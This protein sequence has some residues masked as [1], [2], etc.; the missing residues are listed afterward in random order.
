MPEV[1]AVNLTFLYFV[2]DYSGVKC[3]NTQLKII[4]IHNSRKSEIILC[5]VR[6][7]WSELIFSNHIH[8]QIPTRHIIK[9]YTISLI[10]EVFDKNEYPLK[11]AAVYNEPVPV[12]Q[13]EVITTNRFLS[14]IYNRTHAYQQF[15]YECPLWHY[16]WL[17]HVEHGSTIDF[18]SIYMNCIGKSALVVY[19]GPKSIFLL[20]ELQNCSIAKHVNVTQSQYFIS[21]VKYHPYSY[22]NNSLTLVVS[23]QNSIKHNVSLSKSG[24]SMWTL[25]I[26]HTAGL[27]NHLVI[28]QSLDTK[29]Y[30]MIEF[31]VTIFDG[32]AY[33]TCTYGGLVLTTFDYVGKFKQ[34]QTFADFVERKRYGPYCDRSVET[35]LIGSSKGIVLPGLKGYIVLYAFHTD[36]I[37]DLTMVLSLHPCEGLINPQHTVY[38]P[39]LLYLNDMSTV[40]RS[41]PGSVTV[42]LRELQ[43]DSCIV[44][45]IFPLIHGTPSDADLVIRAFKMELSFTINFYPRKNSMINLHA[46]KCSYLVNLKYITEADWATKY[47]TITTERTRIALHSGCSQLMIT[48]Q[49][50][51]CQMYEYGTFIMKVSLHE[52]NDCISFNSDNNVANERLFHVLSPCGFLILHTYL[53]EPTF[54]FMAG[55]IDDRLLF[56]SKVL[57]N[58][59]YW[60]MVITNSGSCLGVDDNQTKFSKKLRNM[61]NIYFVDNLNLMDKRKHALMFIIDHKAY[62]G[63]MVL[64]FPKILSP[65]CRITVRYRLDKQKYNYSLSESICGKGNIKVSYSPLSYIQPSWY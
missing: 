5:G 1:F 29:Q 4:T 28:F 63:V 27:L 22:T 36:F 6:D 49:Q 40:I 57:P 12:T 43:R 53:D 34:G 60:F 52:S 30:P 14:Y 58:P 26:N 33:D 46:K 24:E 25:S 41:S 19:D 47:A 9:H 7:Q 32:K 20:T 55:Y 37:V 16:S 23:S 21:L 62:T 59:L 35:P 56:R 65:S 10:Y 61:A 50:P 3:V 54:F 11:Y 17:V 39:L 45:Q 64:G 31:A 48:H 13:T 15:V 18:V 8:F 44:I 2:M 38:A 42:S 51:R